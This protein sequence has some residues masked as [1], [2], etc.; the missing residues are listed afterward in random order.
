MT[1][2]SKAYKREKEMYK[3]ARFP[4]TTK[5]RH[6]GKSGAGMEPSIKEQ[7]KIIKQKISESKAVARQLEATLSSDAVASQQ[8]R[9][10]LKGEGHSYSQIKVKDTPILH[11]YNFDIIG[12]VG[13]DTEKE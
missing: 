7:L 11:A 5:I 9:T 12:A 3:T 2:F 10:V 4:S 6:V 13:L 1:A 8:Q